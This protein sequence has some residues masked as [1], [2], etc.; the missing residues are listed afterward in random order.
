[1]ADKKVK[2]FLILMKLVIRGFSGLLVTNLVSD[3]QNSKWRIQYGGQNNEKL[4]N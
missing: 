1:M 3:F 2:N 4:M